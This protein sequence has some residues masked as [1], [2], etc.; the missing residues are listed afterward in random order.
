[1]GRCVFSFK[2]SETGNL[3]CTDNANKTNAVNL[4]HA[5]LQVF[6]VA[7]LQNFQY[8]SMTINVS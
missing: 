4:K 1:M 7:I 6:L 8:P 3:H 5:L 2:L